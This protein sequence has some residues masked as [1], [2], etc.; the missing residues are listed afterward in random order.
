MLFLKKRTEPSAR[1][2]LA[3]PGCRLTN[4]LAEAADCAAAQGETARQPV[5]RAPVA[6]VAD[7][8]RAR[9]EGREVGW[10]LPREAAHQGPAGVVVAPAD[11]VVDDRDDLGR[12]AG[13]GIDRRVPG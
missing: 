6:V 11:R 1:R 13:G 8:G 2:K 4:P 3:P 9:L 12:L 7:A 10:R 5:P